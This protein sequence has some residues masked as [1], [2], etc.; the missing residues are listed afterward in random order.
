MLCTINAAGF[1]HVLNWHITESFLSGTMLKGRSNKPLY[2]TE[3]PEFQPGKG[4][5]SA[6]L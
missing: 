2:G 4:R 6:A 1:G 5:E 3:D